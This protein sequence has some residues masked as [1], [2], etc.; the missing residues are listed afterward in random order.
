MGEVQKAVLQLLAEVVGVLAVW[1]VVRAVWADVLKGA[2]AR[3][4]LP[5]HMWIKQVRKNRKIRAANDE[6]HKA[7]SDSHPVWRRVRNHR[8]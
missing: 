2:I 1:L 6:R 3:V 8:A 4:Q 5:L 7:L